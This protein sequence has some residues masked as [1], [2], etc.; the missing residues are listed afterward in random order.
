MATTFLQLKK[1]PHLIHA[2]NTAWGYLRHELTYLAWALMEIALL[3]PTL[4]SVLNWT[5]YWPSGQ[6]ALW[7]L[8]LMLL[9][10]NLIRLMSLIGLPPERQR[11][12][13]VAALFL[14][15]F[16][17]IRTILHETQSLFDMRWLA[18]F[19]RSLAEEG[20]QLW[21][22]DIALFLI[23]CFMWWRGIR[24][25]YHT[26]SIDRAGLRLR[27]GG[28]ILAPLVI[29]IASDLLLQNV[30]PFILLFFTAGL[31]AIAL[32]R[33]EQTEQERSGQAASL[34][35]QWVGSIFTAALVVVFIA[36][37]LATLV[38]GQ[39]PEVIAVWVAPIFLAI[40]MTSTAVLTTAVYV[41]SPLLNLLAWLIQLIFSVLSAAF[42]GA[43]SALQDA[44]PQLA[45]AVTPETVA[46][47][48]EATQT[49]GAADGTKLIVILL[50]IAVILLVSLALSRLFRQA[51]VA[52][53][54]SEQ[55]GR[56]SL[57]PSAKP[58][59]A[60]LV[61][62]K[63]GLLKGLRTA[64]SIRRLYWQ[65]CRAAAGAGYP[66]LD[67]ETPYEYLASLAQVWPTN[68]ADSRLITRAYVKIR[69][70]ELPESADEL[71][72]IRDAWQRLET[73]KP[74]Q[75]PENEP[76]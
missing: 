60:R 56:Q 7:L 63:L 31:T 13:M 37:F 6:V 46:Q 18:D 16:L 72:E 20:N 43:M 74:I 55:I 28:L 70:G 8:L 34:T 45:P 29:W 48:T 27:V 12:L 47:A 73:T 42:S 49:E 35:P 19:Y 26:P 11:W 61:L 69:Y 58:G 40:R 5:R 24:L 52:A 57:K 66:R 3:V 15:V 44:I 51:T 53:R 50:M 62:E 17:G 39:P 21:T 71:K 41:A 59:L 65:M 10:F 30:M 9:S 75:R 32:I 33:A 64:I 1:S 2:F 14:T 22:R 36:S 54:D 4:L 23:T 25:S 76:I 67:V 68:T 38:S